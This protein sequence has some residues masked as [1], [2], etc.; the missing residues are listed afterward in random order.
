MNERD[1]WIDALFLE[2]FVSL[3]SA[4]A[5]GNN[6]QKRS[7]RHGMSLV[8]FALSFSQYHAREIYSELFF[9]GG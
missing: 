3:F 9:I 6:T 2:L 8:L 7:Q 5:D 4:P 1:R